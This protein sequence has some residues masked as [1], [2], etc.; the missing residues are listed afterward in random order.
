MAELPLHSLNR[1]NAMHD[2]T[3]IITRNQEQE[4]KEFQGRK[5][6]LP[7]IPDDVKSRKVRGYVKAVR[8]LAKARKKFDQAFRDAMSGFKV[9]TGS[10]QA[11]AARILDD[12]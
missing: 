1:E 9:L 11:Q 3:T 7:P 10:Q 12:V 8:R 6:A 2:L 4:V 5:L